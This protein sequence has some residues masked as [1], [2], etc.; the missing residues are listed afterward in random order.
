MKP[1]PSPSPFLASAPL[2]LG[3]AV[4]LAPPAPASPAPIPGDGGAVT[5]LN[6]NYDLSENRLTYP[7]APRR[8]VSANGSTTETLLA[9]GLGDSMVGS[10]Y[11]DN[12]VLPEYRE[13]YS[14]LHILSSRYPTRESVL[15]VEPDI[16]VGWH[17]AFAPQALGD[18]RWWN[19]LGIGTYIFVDTTPLADSLETVLE[20]VDGLGRIF[21]RHAE[22]RSLTDSIRAELEAVRGRRAGVSP[23]PRVLLLEIFPGQG[24]WAWGDDSTQ[25][26]MLG[27]LNAENVFGMSGIRGKEGLVAADPDAIVFIYMDR[28]EADTETL[29][30]GLSEDPLF[31]YLKVARTGRTGAVPLSECRAPGVRLADGIRHMEEI[32]YGGPLPPMASAR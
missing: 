29:M 18:T 9:L 30:A 24:L 31:K 27:A 14:R 20:D 7:A 25:G 11:Q 6:V 15:S 5:V 4:L 16:I 3:L 23:R 12:P 13:A 21:R 17:S 19:G 8:A 32:I 10:A 2:L 22:A 1:G 28:T 26:R